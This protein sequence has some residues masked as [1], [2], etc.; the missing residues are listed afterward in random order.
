MSDEYEGLS[1]TFAEACR[2]ADEEYRRKPKPKLV[3]KPRKPAESTFQA[4]EF[5]WRLGDQ[6]RLETWLNEHSQEE[7]SAILE[8]LERKYANRS[9]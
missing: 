9:Q 5:L 3:P 1:A 4:A 7:V 8:H 2:K 6:K